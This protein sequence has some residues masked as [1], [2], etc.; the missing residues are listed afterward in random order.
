MT[1]DEQGN[2]E[3]NGL[4]LGKYYVKEL[5]PPEG[6]LPDTKE[7]NLNCGYEGDMT[8]TVTRIRH[9][10]VFI[11]FRYLTIYKFLIIERQ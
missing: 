7:H 9:T 3:A 6:Y 5:T 4:Y 10:D 1:V 11:F 2:A 8:K